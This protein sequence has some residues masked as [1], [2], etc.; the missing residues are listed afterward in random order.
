MCPK[1]PINSK[2]LTNLGNILLWSGGCSRG[3]PRHSHRPIIHRRGHFSIKQTVMVQIPQ[4][5]ASCHEARSCFFST[6]DVFSFFISCGTQ[7][8]LI[9]SLANPK[10]FWFE[11]NHCIKSE[12]ASTESMCLD[13]VSCAV[14]MSTPF[15][16]NPTSHFS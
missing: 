13:L 2:N 7:S 8:R 11:S 14:V 12:A 3:R 16:L 15:F 9:D 1:A 4:L 10:G 6:F 5:L